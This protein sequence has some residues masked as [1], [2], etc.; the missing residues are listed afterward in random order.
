MMGNFLCFKSG[1]TNATGMKSPALT[2]TGAPAGTMSFA[3]SL[4]DKDAAPHWIICN[5]PPDTTSL[6]AGYPMTPPAGAQQS[7][8]WYGPGAGDVHRYEYKVWALKVA[9]LPGGCTNM[10][11]AN[12]KR[13][14]INMTLPANAIAS[15][16]VTACGSTSAGCSDCR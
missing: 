15:A 1:Q 2:W 10:S 13:T 11:S 5:L 16:T 14:L 7:N 4:D 12:A 8:S 9:Q 3:V 6:A